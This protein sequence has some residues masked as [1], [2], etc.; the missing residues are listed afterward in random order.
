VT[1]QRRF[2]RHDCITLLRYQTRRARAKW[3]TC[4]ASHPVDVAYSHERHHPH[5]FVL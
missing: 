4:K 3:K 5:F 2:L 1:V